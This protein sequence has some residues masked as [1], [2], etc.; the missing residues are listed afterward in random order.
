M[1]LALRELVR[2]PG[3]FA[4]AGAIL[5]LIALLLMFLGGLLDGLIGASTGAYRAQ[6]A[7]RIVYSESAKSSLVRSRIEPDVREQVEGAVGEGKVGALSVVQL[8][9]RADGRDV[10][11]LIPIALFGY[12]LA[13]S[14]LPDEVPAEGEVYADRTLESEDVEVGTE[15]LLGPSRTPVT[16][17]GFLDDSQYSGQ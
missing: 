3:R 1:K 12:E 7:D 9:A 14:G 2:R 4:L 13:P 15:L 11:D 8:G 6:Q 10:R 16:V 17:I 5:T